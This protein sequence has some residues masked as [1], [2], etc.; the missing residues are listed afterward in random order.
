MQRTESFF[1]SADG[2]RLY[3]QQWSATNPRAHLVI[4][5]GLGEHSDCYDDFV[6]ELAD[7][8]LRV[9]AWDL[10]GHGRSQGAR[11][12]IADIY[13]LTQDFEIFVNFV[14]KLNRRTEPLLLMGHSMGGLVLLKSL[15]G[16]R[17][18]QDCPLILSSPFLG[19]A[20]PVPEWKRQASGV[21][22]QVAPRFTLDA[23]LPPELL[24]RD[25]ERLRRYQRDP[26]RHQKISAGLFE[27]AQSAIE[28][29][30]FHAQAYTAPTLLIGSEAD[31]VVDSREIRQLARHLKNPANE[32]AL[33]PG[34]LHEVFNDLDREDAFA[35]LKRFLETHASLR[36][37]RRPYRI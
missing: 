18:F 15:L 3:Y 5:H 6:H 20:L 27:S 30:F 17:E 8:D 33:L 24:T 35:R 16:L 7:Y 4:I 21:I 9:S 28:S 1:E 19:V 2:L 34:R 29:V 22:S 32:L 14:L 31:P 37:K 13:Q 26:L 25:P 11:G 23:G 10:R 12:A 36:P